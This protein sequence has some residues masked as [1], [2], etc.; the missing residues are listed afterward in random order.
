M[1][2]STR[3]SQQMPVNPSSLIFIPL[4][5]F[6]APFCCSSSHSLLWLCFDVVCCL[7]ILPASLL[8]DLLAHCGCLWCCDAPPL[9]PAPLSGCCDRAPPLGPLL[10]ACFSAKCCLTAQFCL[11]RPALL[12]T[13]ILC[14]KPASCLERIHQPVYVCCCCCAMSMA[15]FGPMSRLIGHDTKGLPMTFT[16]LDGV[17]C[18]LENAWHLCEAIIFP[19]CVYGDPGGDVGDAAGAAGGP[20]VV[21]SAGA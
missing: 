5:C 21:L 2:W 19:M 18:L 1:Q 10:S 15:Y 7:L 20:S 6:T 4:G 16:A 14:L 9:A 13:V 17:L 11:L 8:A 12:T 3:D